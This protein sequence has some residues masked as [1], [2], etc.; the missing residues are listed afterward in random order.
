V[1]LWARFGIILPPRPLRGA[2]AIEVTISRFAGLPRTAAIA[3]L[4]VLCAAFI[5][6]FKPSAPHTPVSVQKQAAAASNDDDPDLVLY[7]TINAR[8]AAGEPYYLVAAQELRQGNYPL[9]PFVTFRLPTLAVISG[10]I[11]VGGMQVLLMA[12]AL[13]TIGLWWRRLNHALAQPRMALIGGLLVAMGTTL[14]FRPAYVVMHEVWAGL[15]IAASLAVHRADKWW[16]AFAFAVVALA[17]RELALPFILLMGALA[18]CARRWKE[19]ATWAALVLAFAIVIWLHANQVAAVT[20][21]ADPAS[22]GWTTMGGW[23]SLMRTM[24]LTSGFRA[25]P[26]AIATVAIILSFLGWAGWRSRTG[27]AGSLMF[28][29]YGLMLMLLGRYE[30]F[31]WGL[32]IAPAFALG[33]IFAPIALKDLWRAALASPAP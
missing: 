28:A 20:S 19:A 6:S 2:K 31:Y 32:L 10:W 26:P 7:R 24:A 8:M 13:L 33:I 15:L 17:L 3:I 16:A 22:P 23:S 27:L 25:L 9:R 1:C 30:N 11:G 21:S 4:L 5:V 12:L 14:A 18:L 29:G